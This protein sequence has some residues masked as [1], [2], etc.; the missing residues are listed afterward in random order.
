LLLLGVFR[1]YELRASHAF[2]EPAN[3]QLNPPKNSRLELTSKDRL[4]VIAEDYATLKKAEQDM[5][6]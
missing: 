6:K 2:A 1:N 4:I 3:I 5:N